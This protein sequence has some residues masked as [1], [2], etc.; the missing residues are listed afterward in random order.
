M[1]FFHIDF[2]SIFVDF[3]VAF[4]SQNRPKS[5]IFEKNEIPKR[6][7]NHYGFANA[8]WMDFE[9]L[10]IRFWSIS[11]PPNGR[12]RM[13]IHTFGENQVAGFVLMIRATRGRS[14][15]GWMDGW[16]STNHWNGSWIV[17]G[18]L[19]DLAFW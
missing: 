4:A 2:E 8:F 12:F 7:L 14:M 16:R 5:L 19:N 17:C 1:L 11:E 18:G 13:K 10:R 6:P 9:A 3:G 15:D